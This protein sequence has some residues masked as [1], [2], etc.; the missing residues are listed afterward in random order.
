MLAYSCGPFSAAKPVR[1]L[2]TRSGSIASALSSDTLPTA[3]SSCCSRLSALAKASSGSAA[4]CASGSA[5]WR[6]YLNG[7]SRLNRPAA[8]AAAPASA[9][10]SWRPAACSAAPLGMS[11]A[12]SEAASGSAPSSRRC[13]TATP[14][15][16]FPVARMACSRGQISITSSC[17]TTSR[18]TAL[19]TLALAAKR[20]RRNS[21]T[22]GYQTPWCAQAPTRFATLE[23]AGAACPAA[24]C[25]ADGLILST[26]DALAIWGGGC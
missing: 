11:A 24:G 1:P 3:R 13:C 4:A 19:M 9:S 20:M 15:R 14:A 7:S 22:P 16:S 2:E 18:N 5:A 17:A 8:A 26:T 12:S 6:R 21:R 25:A 10:G 23:C